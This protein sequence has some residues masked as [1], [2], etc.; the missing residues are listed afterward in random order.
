MRIASRRT[1]EKA[2][3]HVLLIAC[4]AC[5][6]CAAAQVFD[7]TG[8]VEMNDLEPGAPVE[9]RLGSE[10]AVA[11]RQVLAA[12]PQ[13]FDFDGAVFAFD[14]EGDGSLTLRQQ[15]DPGGSTYK[16]GN[17][18]AAD[19]DHAAVGELGEIH[20][21]RRTG[22]GWSRSHSITLDDVVEPADVDVRGMSGDLA[23]SGNLLAIGD[24]SAHV[25][26]NG[27]QLTSAGAVALFR[28]SG[29][30]G[31]WTFEAVLRSPVPASSAS[32]GSAVAVS[33]STVLVGANGEGRAW[34]FQR[35]GAQWSTGLALDSPGD[36]SFGW[37]VALDRD[38]AVV[39]RRRGAVVPGSSNNGSFRAYER[40]LG[41]TGSW[42]LRGEYT[43]SISTYIDEFSAGL[44]L[45]GSLLLVGA[46]G[47]S[48]AAFFRHENGAGWQEIA[49]IDPAD[50]GHAFGTANFGT[51]VDFRGVHAAIGAPQ[52]PDAGS[53]SPRW[54]SL[55]LWT[56]VDGGCD[57]PFDS[58]Y[59]DG[60]DGDGGTATCCPAAP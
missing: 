52:F 29:S 26:A 17:Q 42:G 10:L 60:F 43:S 32:F 22:S 16:F 46:P 59:C 5:A 41:G 14:I 49:T 15:L 38:L 36:G 11:G 39:G 53:G 35:S 45:H 47:T 19:A 1:R 8:F 31:I 2:M 37:S 33:G 25:T 23:L 57:D 56:D 34:V 27:E 9:G 4:M 21:Y 51:A 18:L 50:A 3:R 30:S 55:H 40:D 12:A 6:P 48:K 44:A 58:I 13:A 28:R 7:E 54:G 24:T 20:L